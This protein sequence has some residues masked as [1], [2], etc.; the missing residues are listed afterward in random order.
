MGRTM[1]GHLLA[2][3]IAATAAGSTRRSPEATLG[4]ETRRL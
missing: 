1:A 2:A 4:R 3:R